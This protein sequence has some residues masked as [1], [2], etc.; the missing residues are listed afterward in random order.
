MSAASKQPW[1][2]TVQRRMIDSL[3]QRQPLNLAPPPKSLEDTTIRAGKFISLTA[4]I[5]DSD[6]DY[7]ALDIV[8]RLEIRRFSIED[9]WR[10]FGESVLPIESPRQLSPVTVAKLTELVGVF[11]EYHLGRVGREDLRSERLIEWG[12]N[13]R[14]RD[15]PDEI[16][17]LVHFRMMMKHPVINV[18]V[19]NAAWNH[20][21]LPD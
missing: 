5:E 11:F 2:N 19:R 12:L 16:N 3:S 13:T 7:A 8:D 10:C 6:W 21:R 20:Y 1:L 17:F 4:F 9:F 14:P 15:C 18:G